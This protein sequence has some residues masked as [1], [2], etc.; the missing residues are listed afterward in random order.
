GGNHGRRLGRA[1]FDHQPGGIGKARGGDFDISGEIENDSRD[2]GRGLGDANAADEH[3]VFE[4]L[5]EG[6]LAFERRARADNIEVDALGIVEAIGAEFKFAGNF[7]GDASDLAE[8]PVAHGGD[9][10]RGRTL[11]LRQQDRNRYGER[12][13]WFHKGALSADVSDAAIRL[14]FFDY[15]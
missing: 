5:T 2:A 10:L 15:P 1:R 6:A 14:F 11:T 12:G 13:E 8:R 9:G 4:G 7:D 3:I